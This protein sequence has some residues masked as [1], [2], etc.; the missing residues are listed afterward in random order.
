MSWRGK[1][2][3]R[4]VAGNR[5]IVGIQYRTVYTMV[6]SRNTVPSTWYRPFYIVECRACVRAVHVERACLVGH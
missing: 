2:V 6:H 3:L 4:H 5:D 1:A